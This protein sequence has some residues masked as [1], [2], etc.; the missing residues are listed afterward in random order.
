MDIFQKKI[1]FKKENNSPGNQNHF[2]H[3]CRTLHKADKNYTLSDDHSFLKKMIRSG[4]LRFAGWWSI[5]AGIL[6]INSVCPI[7]GSAACPVGIGTTG[8]IAGFFAAIKQWGGKLFNPAKEK[9]ILLLNFLR[10]THQNTLK[11]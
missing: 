11:K 3:E 2:N 8:I 7:C 9:L 5:F 4:A 6:A 1:N 10:I